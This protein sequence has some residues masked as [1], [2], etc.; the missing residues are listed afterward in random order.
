MGS[1][2]DAVEGLS[3]AAHG[4]EAA[5]TGE[6]IRSSRKAEGAATVS[7]RS[8]VQRTAVKIFLPRALSPSPVHESKRRRHESRRRDPSAVRTAA[9]AV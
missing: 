1:Y 5:V 3:H 7:H 8:D 6:L 2:G 4:R 9:L